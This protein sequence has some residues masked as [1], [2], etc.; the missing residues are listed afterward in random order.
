MVA[1]SF[2]PTGRPGFIIEEEASLAEV[3][4]GKG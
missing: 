2:S 1:R 3:G 4:K